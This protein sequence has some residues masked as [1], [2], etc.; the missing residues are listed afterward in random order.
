MRC[1][2]LDEGRDLEDL[3][4]LGVVAQFEVRGSLR[5]RFRMKGIYAF[6]HGVE[7]RLDRLL[8]VSLGVALDLYYPGM[9]TSERRC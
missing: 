2:Q 9:S 1:E 3:S 6:S 8:V 4:R 5:S 7:S